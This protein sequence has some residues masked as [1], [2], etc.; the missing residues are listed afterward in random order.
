MLKATKRFIAQHVLSNP[1]EYASRVRKGL[2]LEERLVTI[3]MQVTA[4]LA[5]FEKGGLSLAEGLQSIETAGLLLGRMKV[6]IDFFFGK[7]AQ[8]LL[9]RAQEA[10][11]GAQE[12][13]LALRE[14]HVQQAAAAA[15]NR[16]DPQTAGKVRYAKERAYKQA[17]A[18]CYEAFVDLLH[19]LHKTNLAR[20]S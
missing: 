1:Q 10:R 18:Q 15:G 19:L 3:S 17:Q 8:R 5:Q 7:R 6:D 16:P 20:A 12:A 2:E 11:L 4:P 14:A 9:Q 13:L